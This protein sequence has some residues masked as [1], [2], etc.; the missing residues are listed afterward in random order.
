MLYH[1]VATQCNI[2][3]H[4]GCTLASASTPRTKLPQGMVPSDPKCWLPSMYVKPA[5]ESAHHRARRAAA[6]SADHVCH[7]CIP[8][9]ADSICGTCVRPCQ[10]TSDRWP[11]D[12]ICIQIT[13]TANVDVH[14]R[15]PPAVAAA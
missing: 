2:I 9:V 6:Q 11:F 15:S 8:C 10:I 14:P 13:F 3:C 7:S 12:S 1:D 5:A 4:S